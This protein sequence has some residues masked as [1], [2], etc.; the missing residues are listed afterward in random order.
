MINKILFLILLILSNLNYAYSKD[1]YIGKGPLTVGDI[2]LDYFLNGYLKTPA[3]QK[4]LVFW[5][6]QE[7]SLIHI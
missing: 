2:D 3:G 5:I 4:P 6:A 1:K 7:L